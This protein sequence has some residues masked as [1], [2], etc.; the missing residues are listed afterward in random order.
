MP[1]R[2]PLLFAFC[3]FGISLDVFSQDAKDDYRCTPCGYDCDKAIFDKRG[4]CGECNMDLVKASSI[5][6]KNISPSAIC[7]FVAKNP[8][9]I[10]LDVRTK[11]EFDGKADPNFGTLKNAI[12]IPIQELEKR[13][14][15]LDKYKNQ[16]IIVFCSHSHRSP[17]ASHILTENGFLNVTNMSDGMSKM[18]DQNCKINF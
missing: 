12:N 16:P 8:D 5:R 9:V 11:T 10:L 1:I 3:I 2:T 15:E 7:E 18:K 13:I 17:R 6:F 14:K 4:K